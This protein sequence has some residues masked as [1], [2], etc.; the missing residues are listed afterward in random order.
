[1]EYP[2][3]WDNQTVWFHKKYGVYKKVSESEVAFL[4]LYVDDILLIRN[5]I[6]FTPVIKDLVAQ[7]FLH[8]IYERSNLYTDIKI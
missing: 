1:L 8:E 5:Y 2:F 7:E 3:W 6:F 4:I